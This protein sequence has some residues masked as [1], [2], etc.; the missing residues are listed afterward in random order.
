GC[1]PMLL[2]MPFLIALFYA[3]RLTPEIMKQ[4]VLWFHLGEIDIL[5]IILTICLYWLQSLVRLEHVSK[6][7][8]K[9]MTLMTF[10]SPLMIGIIAFNI[11]AELTLY[12]AISSV[13][14]TIQSIVIKMFVNNEKVKKIEA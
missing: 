13:T 9:Q 7:Q 5:L 3:V 1:L 6:E 2:Q 12:W 11:P 14:M 8:R 4:S 10:L